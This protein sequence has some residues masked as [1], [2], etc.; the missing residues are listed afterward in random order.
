MHPQAIPA[1]PEET[2]RVA[3]AVLPQ[4]NTSMQMR[5]ELGTL[6]QDE[7]FQDLFPQRGQPAEAPWHLALVTVMHYA[8]GLT[9]KE[10]AQQLGSSPSTVRTQL[11]SVYRRLGV[12]TRTQLQRAIATV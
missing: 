2:A 4:G 9:H 6:Y 8:E 3:R 11:Q 5:D 10:I 7:D 1:I 12:H